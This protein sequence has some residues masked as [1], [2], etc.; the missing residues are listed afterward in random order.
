MSQFRAGRRFDSS[1]TSLDE[2][3]E[4]MDRTGIDRSVVC[5][6]NP[7]LDPL[8]GPDSPDIARMVN[9]ELSGY[10]AATG[11]RV[12]CMGVLP[13]NH[14]PDAVAAV[15]D[16]T[17]TAGLYGI[18]TGT[19]ICGLTLDDAGLD[20]LWAALEH[21]QIPVFVHPHYTAAVENLGGFG[22]ALPVS[23]GFPSETTI[24][25]AR[26]VFAGVLYRYP[27]LKM[28]VA[29][30]GGA[31]PTLAGRMDAA[32]RS[33]PTTHVRLPEPPSASVARLYGDLVLYQR[34]AMLAAQ[35]MFGSE[36]LVYG[37]DHPF[38]V[39][40]PVINMSELKVAFDAATRDIVLS[41]ANQLFGIR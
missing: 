15:R 32:W 13:S 18:V 9:K 23:V 21:H 4:F 10:E 6:G 37:T 25:V 1:Y 24:A 31:L 14:V 40:D 7:W 17:L 12:V 38:S 5:L 34:R 30:G 35:S 36:K 16:V 29:H 11:G 41:G 19:L 22:H 20:P 28:L 27:G 26:L 3:L 39:S 2:K 33:D 8:N